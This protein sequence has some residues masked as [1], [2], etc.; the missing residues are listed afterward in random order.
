MLKK[1]VVAASAA[2]AVLGAGT[3]ALASSGSLTSSGHTA[4]P[5]PSASNAAPGSEAPGSEARGS[6]APG[7]AGFGKAGRGGGH[8]LALR[9]LRGALHAQW[10]TRDGNSTTS[11]VTHDAI[12]GVVTAVSAGSITV[13]AADGVT[14][15]YAVTSATKVHLRPAG[16]GGSDHGDDKARGR[17]MGGGKAGTISD[18]HTGDEVAVAGTGTTSLTARQIFDRAR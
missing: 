6:A 4:S 7:H 2:A 12:R 15:S 9:A 17:G 8:R 18:V 13:K 3:A 10:V 16:P 1:I 11:F 5:A 14:Q